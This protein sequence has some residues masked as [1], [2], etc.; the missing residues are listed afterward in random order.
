M[1]NIHQ[2]GATTGEAIGTATELNASGLVYYVSSVQGH[3][4]NSGLSRKDP[5]DT[6]ANGVA[7]ASAGDIIVLLSDHAETISSKVTLAARV[8]LIGEGRVSGVPSATL[9]P[10]DNSAEMIDVTAAGCHI[11]N[12]RFAEEAAASGTTE[13]IALNGADTTFH[14][15]YFEQDENADGYCIAVYADRTRFQECTFISTATVNAT[16]ANNDPPKPAIFTSGVILGISF[17]DCVFNGGSLGWSGYALDLSN[18]A[19]TPLTGTGLSFLNGADYS[20]NSSTVG[21]L[22][23]GT[24]TG[25]V[26]GVW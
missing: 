14:S 22:G 21:F 23:I 6:L 5:L 19:T 13:R 7:A 17:E 1:A 3:S 12:I 9:T 8:Y 25:G 20:V 15:C 16:P 4:G 24:K 18:A 26:T 2:I 11:R 10:D